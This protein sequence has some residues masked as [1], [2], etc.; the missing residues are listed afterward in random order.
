M[1]VKLN[2]KNMIE[3]AEENG[4]SNYKSWKFKL[5]LLLEFKDLQDVVY[6][7]NHLKQTKDTKNGLR[8][9]KM[10]VRTLIGLNVEEKIALKY[11][12]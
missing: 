3:A 1:D 5:D 4:K 6:Y 7:L 2:L 9:I 12:G 8:Q 10:L 11:A